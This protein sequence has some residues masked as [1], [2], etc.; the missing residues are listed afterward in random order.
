MIRLGEFNSRSCDGISRR[1]FVQAGGALPLTA[2]FTGDQIAKAAAKAR[3]KS[4]LFIWLWG[5]PSHIDTFDPKPDAPLDFRGPF[6]TIPTTIPGVRFSELIPKLA[7]RTDKYALIRSNITHDGGHPGAGTYGYTGSGEGR[8]ATIQPSWGS[9]VSRHQGASAGL[10]PYVMLSRGIPRDV[11]KFVDGYG[12][13]DWGKAYDPFLI[14]CDGF[15]KVDIPALKLVDGITPDRIAHRKLLQDQ[16]D[17]IKRKVTA[18]SFDLWDQKTKQ[19]FTLLTNKQAVESLDLTRETVETR[20]DY[21][22]TSFGQS[23]LL[24][25]RLVEA[26]VPFVNVSWSEYVESYSPN[27][28]FGWDTHVNNFDLLPNRH[29]PILDKALSAL[30]DDMDAR[31]LLDSTL[32]VCMGE[33]GRTPRINKRASRDHWAKNYFSIWAGA[34][35]KPGRVIGVS[36]AKAENPVTRPIEPTGVGVTMLDCLGIHSLERAELNVLPDGDFIHELF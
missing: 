15:G 2:A 6:G 24:A 16:L 18:N 28:D 20:E 26:E 9:I 4:V 14:Q 11:A 35:V 22:Q 34:G 31:G 13:G 1:A 33:F 29:C 19:A 10:P 25:R 30:L 36:D 7:A 21:G 8:G 3:A 27:T 23:L 17:K 5:A 32:V 12:G